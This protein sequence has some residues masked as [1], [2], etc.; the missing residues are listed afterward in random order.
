MAREK[1]LPIVGLVLASFAACEGNGNPEVKQ[2]PAGG[3]GGQ[4][5]GGNGQ[6]GNGG[7]DDAAGTGGDATVPDAPETP[8]M[9]GVLPIPISDD[10]ASETE[11][12]LDAVAM[13]SRSVSLVRRWDALFSGPTTPANA[14]WTQ[15]ASSADFYAS[16]SRKILVCLSLVD[17]TDPARP[18]G[19]TGA[20]DS[21]A[22]L[23]ALDDLIDKTYSTFGSELV[24][25]SFGNEID[26][27]LEQAP[28]AEQ[29]QLVALVEHGVTY[30]K[31]HPARPPESAVG[32]TFSSR[33]DVPLPASLLAA[34]DALVFVYH[35]VD[36][37]FAAHPPEAAA[38]LDALAKLA[39]SDA[40]NKP[41]FLQSVA[42]PSSE[43]NE[44]SPEQQASF[45]ASL[46]QALATRRQKFP[47][48]VIE[49]LYD[50]STEDCATQA[51]LIGAA[52]SSDAEAM[53]CSFGL[54]EDTGAPKPA[55][56]T[57]LDGLATFSS[58]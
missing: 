40:G 47:F 36:E 48:V 39:E 7:D 44:S 41:V 24:A 29:A 31:N 30:A 57:V 52:A 38:G 56:A 18:V 26:R 9:L 6:G 34:S 33:A 28:T 5:S 43:Q 17:R 25:L 53:F 49:G 54:R 13:G 3:S 23:A 32:V 1:L 12:E 21:S 22:T 46:F 4:S 10:P 55:Q 42:Y 14:E 27:F 2:P 45:Y 20:W 50:E 58:P 35:A 11:A 8:V 37:S 16:I 51:S 15:L 19:L